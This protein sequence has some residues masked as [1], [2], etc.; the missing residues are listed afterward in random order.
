MADPQSLLIALDAAVPLH[1]RDL[2]GQPTETL[3][4]IAREAVNVI[5]AHGDDLL[6]GG[7]KCRT[8]FT[9]L[10]VALAALAHAPGGVTFSGRHWCTD[11]DACRRAQ[12]EALEATR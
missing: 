1:I 12:A 6:Y 7:R 11:H 2:A 10:A 5:A 8:T 4:R 3:Q 9:A